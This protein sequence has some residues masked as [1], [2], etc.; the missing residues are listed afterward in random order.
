MNKNR[1]LSIPSSISNSDHTDNTFFLNEQGNRQGSSGDIKSID[2]PTDP[3]KFGPGV[4]F[5]IH[6]SAVN[7]TEDDDI[8]YFIKQIKLLIQKLP[9]NDCSNH[10]IE[11]M[12]NNPIEQF[13]ELKDSEG[14]KIGM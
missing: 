11:Y 7:A 8:K 10:A 6:L 13:I 9:C 4:W 5:S 1:F 14:N 2:F 3:K 12:K